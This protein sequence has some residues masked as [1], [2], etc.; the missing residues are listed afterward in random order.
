MTESKRV[1]RPKSDNPKNRRVTI[2]LTEDEFQTMERVSNKIN[3][4]KTEAIMRGI[5]LLDSES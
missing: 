5:E 3:M 4:T 2:R 1:G